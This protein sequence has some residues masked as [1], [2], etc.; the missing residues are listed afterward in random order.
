MEQEHVMDECVSVLQI[1]ITGERA[2]RF[3]EDN[4]DLIGELTAD[5]TEMETDGN[6]CRITAA[7]SEMPLAEAPEDFESFRD[8]FPSVI[9]MSA[10]EIEPGFFESIE[11][12]EWESFLEADRSEEKTVL[13]RKCFSWRRQ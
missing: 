6:V 11:A 9:G 8:L 10:E 5:S 1:R 13:E 12:V 2:V 7:D 4:R 3:L